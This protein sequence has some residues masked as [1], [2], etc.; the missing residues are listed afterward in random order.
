MRLERLEDERL[1]RQ[2]KLLKQAGAFH[3]E[4][5]EE[6]MEMSQEL[7][8]MENYSDDEYDIYQNYQ[9]ALAYSTAKRKVA[10][11]QRRDM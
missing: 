8:A 5:R 3:G 9:M 7:A 2:A 10:Q 6:L 1:E 11:Q 4:K